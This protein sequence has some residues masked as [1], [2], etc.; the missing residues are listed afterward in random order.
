MSKYHIQLFPEKTYHLLSR[1]NGSEKLFREEENYRFFLEKMTKYILPVVRIQSY[2]LLPN[3]FHLLAKI[4]EMEAI[5]EH[6]R[7]KK[8]EVIFREEMASDFIMERFSNMLNS[9]SKSFNK[10]YNRK[11]SLFMDYMRRVEIE[12]V[13][14]MKATVFYIHKNPVHHGYCK[15]PREWEWS[16]YRDFI[17]TD[18]SIVERE[19]VFE[20]FGGRSEFFQYHSRPLCRIASEPT[21]KVLSPY[22]SEP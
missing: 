3:H 9:Y 20:N 6:F 7:I 1:A 5:E 22:R 21:Y 14:Q 15:K 11:G 2:C 13:R 19:E 18:W 12:S 16:S 17:H 8:P 10:K 4:R